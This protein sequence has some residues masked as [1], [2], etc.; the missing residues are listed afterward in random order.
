MR[1]NIIDA[2]YEKEDQSDRITKDY[3]CTTE[4]GLTVRDDMAIAIPYEVKF[5]PDFGDVD[6]SQ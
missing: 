1:K 6:G 2:Y 4:K 3:I 5:E